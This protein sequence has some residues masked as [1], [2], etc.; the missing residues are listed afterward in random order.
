M[1][2]LLYDFLLV[3]AG[4]IMAPHL[5]LK[6]RRRG[7]YRENFGNRLGRFSQSQRDAF[8][9]GGAILI[10]AASVGEVGVAFQFIEALRRDDP[11]LRFVV[12]VTSSTGWK[13]AERRLSPPDALVYCPIDLPFA[14]ARALD[15]I[16][17]SAFVMVETEIW[18]NLLR[19]CHARGIPMAIVNGRISDKS[20]PS[21]RRLRFLFGPALRLVRLILAQ[22]ALDAERFEAA[23]ANPASIKV[24][25]SFKFDVARR[26]EAKEAAW[27][28]LLAQL[29]LLP[30]TLLLVGAS[31]WEGEEALLMDCYLRLR[32]RHP[33]L[34][35][36][37]V[38][39]H[40]ERRP[41][42][43]AAAAARSLRAVR[44][45]DLDAA[46]SPDGQTAFG[47][48]EILLVDTTGEMMGLYPFATI[49]VVGRSFRSRGGQNMIEPCL[50]GVP[51]IVGPETQNFRPVMADLLASKALIQVP[52]DAA[53]EKALD[54]LLCDA[55]E[56]EALGRRA[57]EAV[58]ARRGAV[59]VCAAAFREACLGRRQ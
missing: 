18:P 49:A 14:V 17:P 55:A 15:A 7:G 5:I 25:G 30:P 56:R 27:K 1:I 35:L 3:V 59:G 16:R 40:F 24:T 46:A 6:M 53:L 26:N 10:H 13:E 9:D 33:A 28:P 58:L 52:D 57:S 42:V 20:A 38:P 12:S 4:L 36:A 37:L 21:Y 11:S 44:K 45:S 31:T 51:T 54:A 19:A 8:G 48:D 23:G 47:Q 34:R 22:S 2:W 43:E 39:R 32:Q 50:C 41:A 29:G